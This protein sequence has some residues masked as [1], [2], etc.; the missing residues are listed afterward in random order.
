MGA[1]RTFRVKIVSPSRPAFE[2]DDVE[3]LAVPIPTGRLELAEASPISS[4][5]SS[6]APPRCA[7]PAGPASR[8]RWSTASSF[9]A[10]ATC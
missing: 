4:P 6:P 5:P 1:A 8:S 3:G 7:A 2:R 9:A 10:A